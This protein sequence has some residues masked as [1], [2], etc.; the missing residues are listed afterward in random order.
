MLNSAVPAAMTDDE[1]SGDAADAVRSA[2]NTLSL[3]IRGLTALLTALDSELGARF[4]DAVARIREARGRVIVTGMGKSG[5]VGRKL[6]ATFASTGTPA[7]FV[8]PGE[9]SHGDLGMVTPEDVVVALSWSGETVEL[10]DMLHHTRRYR[11]PLIAVTSNGESALGRN[12]DIAL[13][14]PKTPEACPHG[15]APTTSTTMQLAIGDALAVALLEGRSFSAQDFRVFHPGGKLGA[16]LTYVRDLM[17]R[18]GEIPLVPLGTP[19]SEAI[20]TISA[21]SF[22][23]VGVTDGDGR[24][25]GIVTDGDLRRHM[26]PALLAKPI[27]AVMTRD[28]CTIAPLTMAGAALEMMTSRKITSLFVVEDGR[29]VG[30][31]HVHDTLRHGVA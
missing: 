21:H 25:C 28:P 3:E 26:G 9:A 13:V 24:L 5:H 10:R 1:G 20:L 12:A 2:R 23:C 11:V 30:I 7:H 6:A 19:M 17:H 22:G 27:D 15:L 31:V 14:L 18:D 16:G 8:H 29:P 4:D